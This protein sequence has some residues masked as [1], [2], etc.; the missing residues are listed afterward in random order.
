MKNKIKTFIDFIGKGNE[1]PDCTRILHYVAVDF[2]YSY[3]FAFELEN[4]KS[5]TT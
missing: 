3:Y 1:T 5:Y 2:L 4:L